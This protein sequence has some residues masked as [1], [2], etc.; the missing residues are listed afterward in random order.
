MNFQEGTPEE[1]VNN[2]RL[3]EIRQELSYMDYSALPN[4]E[5]AK[6][7]AAIDR[8][9]DNWLYVTCPTCKECEGQSVDEPRRHL[10]GFTFHPVSPD[11]FTPQA[12]E[13]EDSEATEDWFTCDECGTVAETITEPQCENHNEAYAN[14]RNILNEM[15]LLITWADDWHNTK[16]MLVYGLEAEYIRTLAKL[17]KLKGVSDDRL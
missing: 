11:W 3:D 14:V 5:L 1:T 15:T 6:L 16:K 12:K 2:E 7:F 8:L 17:D 4:D 9:E 10:T 13:D